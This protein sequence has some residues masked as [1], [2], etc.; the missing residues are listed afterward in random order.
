MPRRLAYF[1]VPTLGLAFLD[2]AVKERLPTSEWLLHER[3]AAWVALSTALLLGCFAIACLSSRKVAV[4]AALA[5]G[6]ALGNLVRSPGTGGPEPAARRRIERD[7]VQP[8]RRLRRRRPAAP[9]RRADVGIGAPSRPADP[10]TPVGAATRPLDEAIG[11]ADR[12]RAVHVA[13]S[14][15]ASAGSCVYS[16]PTAVTAKPALWSEARTS[17][18]EWKYWRWCSV[19]GSPSRGRVSSILVSQVRAPESTTLLITKP[20]PADTP[21]TSGWA[22][23]KFIIASVWRSKTSHPAGRRQP[24]TA[25][26]VSRNSSGVR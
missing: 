14:V 7:R 9:R 18:S 20:F 13:R 17:A 19:K 16:V 24:A 1:I 4:M 26:I 22:M 2:L 15:D 3:S 21:R 10:A 5:A 12:R 6:G 11:R 25:S 23:V 8:R